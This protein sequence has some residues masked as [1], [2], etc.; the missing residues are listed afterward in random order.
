MY[1]KNHVHLPRFAVHA[2]T[3]SAQIK[4][5]R[6]KETV[7]AMSATAEKAAHC[8]SLYTPAFP[9]YHRPLPVF[10]ITMPFLLHSIP[11]YFSFL[12][13]FSQIN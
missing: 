2:C 11:F 10:V 6:P 12:K 3:F 4:K 7:P 9:S 5:A 1:H 13:Q 8:F